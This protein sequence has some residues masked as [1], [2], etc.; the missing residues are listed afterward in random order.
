MLRKKYFKI[1]PYGLLALVL[2][3]FASTLRIIVL[4][5]GWP[6]MN[7]DEGTMGL[8]ARHIAYQGELP[9]FFYGQ[10]YM[11]AL[12]AYTGS[13]LFHIFGPS[14]FS[15]RLGLVLFYAAFLLTLYLLTGILYAKKL[16]LVTLLLLSFGSIEMFTRQLRAV[17]GDEETML[18]S[19]LIMLF[20]SLLILSFDHTF[21]TERKRRYTLY[22]CLGLSMGLGLWSHMLV[23]PFIAMAALFL[24]IYCRSELRGRPILFLLGSF[25]VGLLP[26][27]IFN[28][29]Y[30]A[31]NSLVTLWQLHSSGGLGSAAPSYTVWDEIRGTVLVSLPMTTGANPLCALTDVPGQWRTQISSCMIFQGGWGIG[32]LLLLGVAIFLTARALRHAYPAVTTDSATQSTIFAANEYEKRRNA[33][34]LMVLSGAALTL[35]SYM[36]S[37]APALVPITSTRYLVGLLVATPAILAPL[38]YGLRRR[39]FVVGTPGVD[40]RPQE[41]AYSGANTTAGAMDIQEVDGRPQGSPHRNHS[42]PAPTIR[43]WVMLFGRGCIL[44]FIFAMLVNGTV[45]VFQDVPHVQALNR[46]EGKVVSDLEQ[47]HVTRMYAVYWTCDL[48]MFLSNE[49]IICS[50]VQAVNGKLEPGQNRYPPYTTIVQQDAQADYLLPVG[51]PEAAAF[52]QQMA[53]SGRHYQQTM[54]DGYILYQPI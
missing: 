37:A 52:A 19:A 27:L 31:Q 40:R 28:L 30:P 17:G 46:Q 4:A 38:W 48:V 15:L 45:G 32:Y 16:A 39:N 20:A 7:S 8:M 43:R 29:K 42:T 24:L 50:A 21:A 36:F 2:I 26:L 18:F 14:F 3:L 10:G 34:R 41:V 11:G 53:S 35:L 9:I 54:I 5:Q 33:L 13:V 12:E 47:H 25:M 6:W 1:G 51:S 49:H 22:S 23:L 44:L